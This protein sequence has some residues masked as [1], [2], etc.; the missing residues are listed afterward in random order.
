MPRKYEDAKHP[1]TFWIAWKSESLLIISID[2]TVQHRNLKACYL[3]TQILQYNYLK[4]SVY[5]PID[6]VKYGLKFKSFDHFD[7][8][9]GL[10]LYSTTKWKRLH[11][12]MTVKEDLHPQH[13][14]AIK[15]LFKVSNIIHCRWF[16]IKQ[17]LAKNSTEQLLLQGSVLQYIDAVM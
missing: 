7:D 2:F 5:L 1:S 14:N 15:D 16:H 17:Q 4:N 8:G 6:T 12:Q 10:T 3:L 13:Q 9:L 11:L